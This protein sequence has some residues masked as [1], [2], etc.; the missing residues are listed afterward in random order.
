MLDHFY[1]LL[2]SIPALLFLFLCF[3]TGFF[4]CSYAFPKLKE[5]KVFLPDNR[6]IS[7]SPYLLLL[8]AWFITGTLGVTWL[9]YILA[10]FFNWIG[11]SNPLFLANVF[12]MSIGLLC[13]VYLFIKRVLIKKNLMK[14]DL[15][16]QT[17]VKG[18]FIK[19]DF[20]KRSSIKD[21]SKLEGN[22]NFVDSWLCEDRRRRKIEF[23]LLGFIIILALILMWVTFYIKDDQLH[24]GVSVFSDFSPHLGMIRSFS[25]G[26]NFPTQYSHFAGEDIKYH[27][28]FQFLVGNLEFLG[29]RLDYAFN[30][31]SILSFISAFLLLYLLALKLTGKTMAGILSCLFF[32]FRSSKSL[33]LYIADLP[34]GSSILKQLGENTEFIGYTPNENWGLWNLNV[35]CNQRHLAFGMAAI[36][37][38]IYLFIPHLYEMFETLLQGRK[39]AKQ[40]TWKQS[41][42]HFKRMTRKQNE[43][44]FQHQAKKKLVEDSQKL[45]GKQWIE[46]S[47]KPKKVIR[48]SEFL[49]GE[50]WEETKD[51][52]NFNKTI[53]TGYIPKKKRRN[54][55]W[56]LFFTR[57]AW[58]VRDFKGALACGLILGSLSFFHGAAVIAGLLI[59]F[60]MAMIAKR[61]LE[62]LIVAVL[63][64]VLTL[65]QTNFFIDGSVVSTEFLYGFIAENK[66]FFG[67]LSYLERLLG[68]LPLV[69]L[70]ALCYQKS[71]NR[72]L[73]IAFLAP[74]LF[75]FHVSLT[76]DVTVNHKYIMISCVLLGIFAADL[77]TI[78]LAYK[79][80]LIK[81]VGVLLVIILTATGIYD[82]YVVIR[83]NTA[84]HPIVLDMKDPLTDWIIENADSKDIFLT[85]SYTV[86]QV[87]LGGAMLYQGHQYYAWSAGYDTFGRDIMVK[88][89]YEASTPEELDQLVK[90]NNIRFIIVD[91]D[92][93]ISS[94]YDLNEENIKATYESRY[95]E[96]DGEWKLTIYDTKKAIY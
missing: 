16:K 74:L 79:D 29:L 87:V 38:V 81:G 57:D 42:E 2:H 44:D 25:K 90:A 51:S 55:F 14:R 27:F 63:A 40:Q 4:F 86:N 58:L 23:C 83:K 88:Q 18:D 19:G 28:M 36:F 34:K 77:V 6:E 15:I 20:I 10:Y 45:T 92:N 67:V 49:E 52:Y 80:K 82:F 21:E 64:L 61:R 89:M 1:Q 66:T 22:H 84:I 48:L 31:P 53:K 11:V 54:K 76:V 69:L 41:L 24:I 26:N 91:R 71:A 39:Q 46:P 96:G 59:L 5:G 94:S 3:T 75:A 9:V 33:F 13:S 7:F 85:S 32:A 62:F 78:L 60:I 93:R 73:M 50:D 17:I 95:E 12:T 37:L 35:Y 56:T 70:V 30:I 8:P 43:E 65:L 47:Q 68:I 72:Y